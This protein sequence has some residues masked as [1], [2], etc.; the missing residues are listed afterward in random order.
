M[1]ARVRKTGPGHSS[2]LGHGQD[3]ASGRSSDHEHDLVAA[4]SRGVA[5]RKT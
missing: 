2:E 4:A 3:V 5:W 1:R